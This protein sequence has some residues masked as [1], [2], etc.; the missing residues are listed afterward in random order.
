MC[1][2]A[3]FASALLI[4]FFTGL[5]ARVLLLSGYVFLNDMFT[6]GLCE[7]TDKP[8]LKCNGSCAV[9]KMMNASDSQS[10][11]PNQ[12]NIA[13]CE[14]IKFLESERDLFCCETFLLSDTSHFY[15]YIPP[16]SLVH[17]WGIDRP[18]VC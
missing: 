7:N 15:S 13:D 1:R 10:S 5:F 8:S 6:I 4:L 3:F 2:N 9:M 18:P 14:S 16:F 17:E 11:K 12:T